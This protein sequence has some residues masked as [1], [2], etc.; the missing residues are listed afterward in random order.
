[1]AVMA[2]FALVS[3][4]QANA[5]G[6]VK[7][8]VIT[9]TGPTYNYVETPTA[10]APTG[11][12]GLKA[13]LQ[14]LTLDGRAPIAVLPAGG[15]GAHVLQYEPSTDRLKIVVAATG[16]EVANNVD[17]SETTFRVMTVSK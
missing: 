10:Q 3:G 8:D 16:V 9:F 5:H 14:G 13:G 11:N 6:P 15:N 17:L 4:G 12:T 7:F 2:N 1:M